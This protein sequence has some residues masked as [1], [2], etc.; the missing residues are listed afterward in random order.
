[1]QCFLAYCLTLYVLQLCCPFQLAR[2]DISLD[3]INS[4]DLDLFDAVL[5]QEGVSEGVLGNLISAAVDADHADETGNKN[6][7]SVA[8][9]I[10][11]SVTRNTVVDRLSAALVHLDESLMLKHDCGSAVTS[12]AAEA[13][14]T[15][16]P[17]SEK[18]S[19]VARARVFLSRLSRLPE[20]ALASRLDA[21]FVEREVGNLQLCC[22]LLLEGRSSPLRGNQNVADGVQ[23]R[24]LSMTKPSAAELLWSRDKD[25]LVDICTADFPLCQQYMAHMLARLQ[26]CLW[27]HLLNDVD[28]V[29][30]AAELSVSTV[31]GST[32]GIDIDLIPA[33][34]REQVEASCADARELAGKV[35][36]GLLAEEVVDD[37]S[38]RLLSVLSQCGCVTLAYHVWTRNLLCRLM[39]VF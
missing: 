20:S 35:D 36:A 11:A 39:N 17:A 10:A 31:P 34:L 33:R 5:G 13:R 18:A 14:E 9:C 12:E 24:L 38:D 1:M 8:E 25:L 29:A 27:R 37:I 26:C 28:A 32:S 16:M 19:C 4:A 22:F 7:F 3:A 23:H 6:L 2:R 15:L 30:A 21:L